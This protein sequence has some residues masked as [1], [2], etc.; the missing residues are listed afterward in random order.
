[1]NSIPKSSS[2][3]QKAL[4]LCHSA[5]KWEYEAPRERFAV[6]ISKNTQKVGPILTFLERLNPYQERLWNIKA[7][8]LKTLPKSYQIRLCP[9]FGWDRVVFFIAPDMMLCFGSKRKKLLTEH[10]CFSCSC[11]ALHGAKEAPQSALLVRGWEGTGPGQLTW[12]GPGD[13]PNH[14]VL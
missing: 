1:M 7:V 14:T 6:K 2:L 13:V 3:K 12:A 4:K 5:D 10:R 8:Y 9:G 11:A